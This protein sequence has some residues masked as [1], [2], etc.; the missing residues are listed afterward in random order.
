M[1]YFAPSIL[2][3][4]SILSFILDIDDDLLELNTLLRWARVPPPAIEPNNTI[5]NITKSYNSHRGLRKLDG[6][7]MPHD[8]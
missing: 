4:E 3:V 7:D 5:D 2:F 6:A 8:A 1:R